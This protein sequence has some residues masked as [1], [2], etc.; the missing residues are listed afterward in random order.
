MVDPDRS[1][2]QTFVNGAGGGTVGTWVAPIDGVPVLVAGSDFGAGIITAGAG[3]GF[4]CTAG[5]ATEIDGSH[6]AR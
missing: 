2:L 6:C 3:A 4:D 1:G 5:A